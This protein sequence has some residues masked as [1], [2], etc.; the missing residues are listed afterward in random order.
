L[1]VD[2]VDTYT[3]T[4]THSQAVSHKTLPLTHT[5]NNNNNCDKLQQPFE[6]VTSVA[7]TSEPKKAT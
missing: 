2:A 3:H 7:N 1:T 4:Y 6:V 5:H